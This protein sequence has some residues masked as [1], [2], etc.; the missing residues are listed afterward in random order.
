[1]NCRQIY[2]H[3]ILGEKFMIKLFLYGKKKKVCR[4]ARILHLK[5]HPSSWSRWLNAGKSQKAPTREKFRIYSPP[6]RAQQHWNFINDATSELCTRSMRATFWRRDARQSLIIDHRIAAYESS[7]LRGNGNLTPLVSSR[8]PDGDHREQSW[9]LSRYILCRIFLAHILCM[10]LIADN[11]TN[12][13]WWY[14][15]K[16][17]KNFCNVL[18][19]KGK[20][21]L[22]WKSIWESHTTWKIV[23]CLSILW[24]LHLF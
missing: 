7:F 14:K 9:Q 1:M 23:L 16:M 17:R 24:I 8:H 12:A 13:I 19:R 3:G 11:S 5:V 22:R 20:I 15:R 4:L 6:A 18:R 21:E 10:A 2:R